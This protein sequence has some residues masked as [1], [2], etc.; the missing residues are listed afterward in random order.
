MMNLDVLG[1][2]KT[3]DCFQIPT[4]VIYHTLEHHFSTIVNFAYIMLVR[5]NLKFEMNFRKMR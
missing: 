5:D 4:K 1:G 2:F 3:F